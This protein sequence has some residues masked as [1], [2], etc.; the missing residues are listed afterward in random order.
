M[1]GPCLSHDP[2]TDVVL[3]VTRLFVARRALIDALSGQAMRATAET[4]LATAVLHPDAERALF[5]KAERCEELA[6][7]LRRHCV[8]HIHIALHGV[9]PELVPALPPCG[10]ER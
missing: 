8:M 4:W 7:R 6:S 5:D 2:G 10:P 9:A 3:F 1:T